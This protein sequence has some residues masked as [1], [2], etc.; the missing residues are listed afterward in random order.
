MAATEAKPH[1][2]NLSSSRVHVNLSFLGI[3]PHKMSIHTQQLVRLTGCCL[4]G[5]TK[6][7][8]KR[9]TVRLSGVRA[10]VCFRQGRELGVC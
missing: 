10:S 4:A 8:T 5:S 9:S 3:F 1:V 2:H 7:I 6:M